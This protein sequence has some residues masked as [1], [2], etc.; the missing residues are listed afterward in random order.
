M[1][2]KSYICLYSVIYNDE[3]GNNKIDYGMIFANSFADASDYL[4]RVSLVKMG[5]VSSSS[6]WQICTRSSPYKTLSR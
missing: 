6:I 3:E 2:D 5:Q 4:E 1:G